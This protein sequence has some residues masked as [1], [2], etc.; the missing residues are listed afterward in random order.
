MVC[1]YGKEQQKQRKRAVMKGFVIIDDTSPYNARR[2][3]TS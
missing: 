2:R 1:W 3:K